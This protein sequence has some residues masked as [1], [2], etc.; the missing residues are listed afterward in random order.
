MAIENEIQQ[1][2][3]AFVEKIRTVERVSIIKEIEAFA[4]E[5][6]HE[7]TKDGATRE[8]IIV[9]QLVDFLGQPAYPQ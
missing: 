3:H 4:G 6:G 1:L 5:Y 7:V 9:E 8:V 2:L